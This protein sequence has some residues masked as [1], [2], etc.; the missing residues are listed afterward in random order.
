MDP[1]YF[2]LN[3]AVPIHPQMTP[4]PEKCRLFYNDHHAYDTIVSP[5]PVML[6]G[7]PA[8]PESMPLSSPRSRRSVATTPTTNNISINTNIRPAK[9]S[10]RGS[11]SFAALRQSRDPASSRDIVFSPRPFEDLHAERLYLSS[12][13][14]KQT[15]HA[16]GLIRD[17]SSAQR[18]LQ[19]YEDG[20]TYGKARRH[21]KKQ[22]NLLKLKILKVGNQERAIGSRLGEVGVELQSREA[23]DRESQGSC[24]SML[25]DSSASSLGGWSDDGYAMLSAN[26]LSY[27]MFPETPLNALSPSFVPG[28]SFPWSLVEEDETGIDAVLCNGVQKDPVQGFA[29]NHGLTFNYC[30]QV[31]LDDDT[32]EGDARRLSMGGPAQ[33]A[34]LR[35]RLSLPNMSSLWIE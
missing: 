12:S 27:P 23:W 5:T 2:S 24:F 29:S 28:S 14:H 19:A 25:L 1:S 33:A 6:D 35:K 30:C 16:E 26:S 13:L 15:L 32:A 3:G 9:C 17:Y 20:N 4:P 8:T 34:L 7:N 21:L 22:L 10:R 11:D 18:Q 31:D